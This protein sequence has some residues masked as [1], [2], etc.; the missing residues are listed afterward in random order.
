MR[1]Q[2]VDY[3][4]LSDAFYHDVERSAEI[5]APGYVAQIQAYLAPF[6]AL[7]EVAQIDRPVMLG[8]DWMSYTASVWHNPGM[9]V[10]CL[11]A[12]SCAA[13]R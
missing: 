5:A 3:V 13:V 8:D 9:T 2:G 1:A 10:Y 11:T 12:A 7:P 4:V 6:E